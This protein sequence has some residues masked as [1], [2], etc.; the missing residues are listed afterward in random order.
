MIQFE[1]KKKG[2][3]ISLH[4]KISYQL[5]LIEFMVSYSP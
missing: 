2:K 5:V 1:N 3:Y 4:V